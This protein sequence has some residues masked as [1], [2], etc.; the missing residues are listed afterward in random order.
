MTF[1][2][3]LNNIKLLISTNSAS[4]CVSPKICEWHCR[5]IIKKR[6]YWRLFA[7]YAEYVRCL[8]SRLNALSIS[9]PVPLTGGMIFPLNSK[10]N[11][12]WM[13]P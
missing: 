4:R 5:K 7:D 12:V 3:C 9:L 10:F 1:D 13:L 8:T 6:T 11:Y 2:R